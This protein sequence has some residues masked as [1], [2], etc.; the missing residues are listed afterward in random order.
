LPGPA[1]G[2]GDDG[3]DILT[4]AQPLPV[5]I[6]SIILLTGLY[7][8]YIFLPIRLILYNH[9]QLSLLNVAVKEAAGNY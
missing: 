6:N 1:N 3:A 5:I 7:L 4:F 8:P 2:G 9:Y